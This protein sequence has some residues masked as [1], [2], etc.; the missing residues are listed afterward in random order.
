M[1]LLT[2]FGTVLTIVVMW[3]MIDM[4]WD[5]ERDLKQLRRQVDRLQ[6]ELDRIYSER[7]H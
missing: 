5:H 7:T 4:L 6:K 3:K 1:S 2:F